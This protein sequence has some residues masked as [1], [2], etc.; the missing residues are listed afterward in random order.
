MS[1]EIIAWN[2]IVKKYPNC[3]V[4]LENYTKSGYDI[5]SAKVVDTATTKDLA[6]KYVKWRDSGRDVIRC[7]TVVD[8]VISIGIIETGV[9]CGI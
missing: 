7:S 2:E 3:W 6:E 5:V 9:G 8:D 4:F 1:D